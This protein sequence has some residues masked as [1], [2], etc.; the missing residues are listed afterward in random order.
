MFVIDILDLSLVSPEQTRENTHVNSNTNINQI[1]YWYSSFR[2]LD[3]KVHLDHFLFS[4][5]SASL[6]AS[7]V[8]CLLSY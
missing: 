5:N 4:M 2:V 8:S 3:E 6:L 7:S 1:D